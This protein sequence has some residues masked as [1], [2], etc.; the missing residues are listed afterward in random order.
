MDTNSNTVKAPN[1]VQGSVTGYLIGF[2]FSIVL[3]LIAYFLVTS[4][5][6]HGWALIGTLAGLS[7]IQVFFQMVFFLHLGSEKGTHWNILAFIFMILIAVIIVVGSLWIIYDLNDRMMPP[8][9]DM[10]EMSHTS[11]H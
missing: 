11:H 8:M 5:M 1:N 4:H 10:H 3:T 9:T 2:S 7:L 6:L